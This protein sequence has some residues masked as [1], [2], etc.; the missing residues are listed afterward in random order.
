VSSFLTAHQ[1]IIGYSVPYNGKVKRTRQMHDDVWRAAHHETPCRQ[2]GAQLLLAASSVTFCSKITDWWSTVHT[3]VHAFITSRVDYCNALLHGVAGGVIRRLQSVLHAA[4]RLI[5]GI[6]R[7]ERITPTP[8]DTLHWLPITELITFK[9]ATFDCSRGRCPNY[10]G[11]VYTPVHSTHRCC[12]F[13]IA[14]SRP[15]WHRR[16]TRTVHSV[17]LPQFPRVRT[18]DLEQTCTASAKHRH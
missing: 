13:A 1:H 7:Y 8:R 6:R 10:F 11:D 14:I 9:T 16:P 5:T 17:W 18:N 3:L 12:S 4:A 15:R 2:C